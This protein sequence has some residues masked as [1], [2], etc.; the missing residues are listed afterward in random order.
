MS[1]KQTAIEILTR[2]I[3]G[4]DVNYLS[5]VIANGYVQHNPHVPDG[6][7]GLIGMVEHIHA[8]GNAFEIEP[9]RVLEEDDLVAIHGRHKGQATSVAFDIFRFEDG[10]AVEHW[11]C[12]QPEE[13]STVSGRSML[14]GPTQVDAEVDTE[15]SRR[16]VMS[17]YDDVIIN[18]DAAKLGDYL[19]SNYAQHNP[20]IADNAEGFLAFF[21]WLQ[22]ENVSLAV[23]K[24]HRS[25]AEG[26]LVLLQSE[27][28]FAGQP[29]AFYD[30]FRV[31]DKKLVEHWDVLQQIPNEM[32]HSNGIF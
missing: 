11:D 10:L 2:G 22:K 7:E 17:F 29:T 15:E 20:K 8:N 4:G 28:E 13:A 30:L 19:G 23:H 3:A 24:T 16:L 12:I 9:I 27:G 14:D 1:N 25:I 26:D 31:Q 18:G 32:A 21:K 6:R 5:S